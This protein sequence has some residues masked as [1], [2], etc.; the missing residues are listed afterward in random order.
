MSDRMSAEQTLGEETKKPP[1]IY[2]RATCR[3]CGSRH[4][5]LAM[6]LKPTPVADAYMPADRQNKQQPVFPLDL[7]LCL[8]CGL[9]HLPDVIDPQVLYGKYIYETTTSPGLV[10]HF[11]KYAERVLQRIGPASEAF[12]VEIGSNDGTLLKFFQKQGLR[13]LGIDPAAA[14]AQKTTASGTETLPS[15]FSPALAQKIKKERGAADIIIANNVMA[16]I[17]NLEEFL[18]GIKDL[19]APEG[20]FIFETGYLVDTM[21]NMVFDNIYHEHLCYF[22]VKPLDKFFS[23]H[24]MSLIYIDRVPTKGG[25]I[26]GTVQWAA[27]RRKV[28]SSVKEAIQLEENLGVDRIDA[29]RTFVGKIDTQKAKLTKLLNDLKKQG[30]TIAGYG[31]SHSVTTFIYYFDL[32][33]ALEFLLDDN[34]RKYQT[35]SPGW[36]IPVYPSQK[37][38]DNKPDYIVILAWRFYEQIVNTHQA[39]LKQ[40]GHFIIP[41]P[42]LEVI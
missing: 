26:R 32:G 31:A 36:H 33:E 23:K 28:D 3:L 41:L 8:D 38:Y 1:V 5:Q 18:T 29:Y 13:V 6:A 10:A 42:E 4:L 27:G 30:K 34:P 16:N 17:D 19:L 15:F 40:G 7:Y 20:V 35:L 21:Q 25:S 11:Q 2:R 9:A 37:I 24:G 12:V 39:F 22:S 14:I